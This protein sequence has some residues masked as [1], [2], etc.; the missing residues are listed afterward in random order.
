MTPDRQIPDQIQ[1][2]L[3]NARPDQIARLLRD[4]EA[5]DPRHA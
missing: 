4:I 1:Q 5:T 3:A 2:L